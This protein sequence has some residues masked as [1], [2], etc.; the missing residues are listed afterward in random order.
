MYNEISSIQTIK[1]QSDAN[2]VTNVD[3]HSIQMWQNFYNSDNSKTSWNIT[4][5]KSEFNALSMC[6]YVCRHLFINCMNTLEMKAYKMKTCKIIMILFLFVAFTSSSGK[7]QCILGATLFKYAPPSANFKAF[8]DFYQHHD[9]DARTP[10]GQRT[11]TCT[12]THTH[13]NPHAHTH[14]HTHTFYDCSRALSG[15]SCQ[16]TTWRLKNL[17]VI[18]TMNQVKIS[19]W[20]QRLI[21]GVCEKECRKTRSQTKT[22]KDK[23]WNPKIYI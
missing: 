21:K 20:R 8:V 1:K 15:I 22:N 23:L 9:V 16:Y 11:H 5:R 10:Y 18:S 17:W 13:I 14:T 19:H 4:L 7:V 12:Q 2:F 6:V 3:P